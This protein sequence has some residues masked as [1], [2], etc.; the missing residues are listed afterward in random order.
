MRESLPQPWLD[1]LIV[2]AGISGIGAA[3]YLQ[4]SNP[5]KTYAILEAREHSGG[6][7][8]LFKYPG[9][10]SDSDLHTFG[11]AFKAW[12]ED[13]AIADAPSILNYLR[14]TANEYGISAHIRYQH[15]VIAANW[16]SDGAYWQ[17]TV[18]Q[19]DGTRQTLYC[20]WLFCAGGYYNYEQ[21]FR[22][23]FSGEQD[24]AG[25]L[26]H[27][28]HWPDDLDY[29]GKKVVVIGSG[30]T[31]VTLV[32]A[33]A[34]EAAHVTMLQRTPTYILPVPAEDKIANLLRAI[35][36]AD[37][38][39]ALTRRKNIAKQRYLW[40]FCIRFPNL[41]KRLIRWVN[42]KS[43]PAGYEVDKH[44]TPPYNPWDQ[45]LCAVPDGDLYEAIN[46]ARADIVTDQIERITA[47]G[48]LL[49]SGQHLDADIIVTA[50][51]LNILPFGGIQLSVNNQPVVLK[52]TV[53]FRGMMLSDV[54]NFAFAVGY[55]NASWTLKVDLLSQHF[56]RILQYMDEHDYAVY[57][58]K[59]SDPAMP[60][61][62]LLDFDAGYIKRAL[63]ELPRQGPARPWVMS[64][65][66]F[67]DV[68]ILKKDAVTDPELHFYPL[69]TNK[70]QAA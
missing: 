11:F 45:R 54:P 27:P 37:W 10:R 13:K 7:W 50:T 20:R 9:I 1:V 14:N 24:F 41:A 3:Y 57:L 34:K 2:G 63:D 67:E 17:V 53:A 68:K 47:N 70:G 62:P 46:T 58:A 42:R 4:K 29:Q 26:I 65:D 16:H 66:Y 35:L 6:T 51:G 60:T 48:I 15:K 21:G 28:Q 59:V 31:A 38:A 5:H 43:L 25:Q 44:F 39:Y 40:R 23:H 8:A 49:K 55:T 32:P 30:A 18:Q 52:N 33:M 56:C 64:M 22:P 36:P 12:T 19:G 61:R 69:T